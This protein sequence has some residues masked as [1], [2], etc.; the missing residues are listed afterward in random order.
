MLY[1]IFV[2]K[3]NMNKILLF[4]A[5]TFTFSF[6]AQ[7]QITQADFATAGDTV[8]L[9]QASDNGY[10]YLSTGAAFVW[11]F[12]T[13]TPNSQIIKEFYATSSAPL[14]IQFLLGTFAPT[15]YNST[16]YLESTALPI[17]QITSF[18]PITI[19]NIYQF[20][21]SSVDSLTSVGY[22]M[23]IS[24]TEIP[25]QSDTIETHYDLPLQYG[26]SHVS[27]GYTL[28]DFNPVADAKWNQHRERT[29]TVDG[30]GSITTPYGTFNAIRVKHDITEVD[31]IYYTFPFV[32]AIWI[33]LP[34]PTSHEYEWWTNG[35]KEPILKITTNEVLGNELVTAIE[36]RDM[37]RF[38]DAG[39]TDL[40][41]E[42]KVFPNPATNEVNI[43]VKQGMTGFKVFDSKGIVIESKVLDMVKETQIDVAHYAVGVYQIQ[44]ISGTK[45]SVKTFVKR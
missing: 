7:I 26:N 38:L 32:G 35:E 45:S 36:Y 31:S 21:K 29:T 16:Y 40:T 18:L 15:R 19:E 43:S 33:P 9:S 8:R 39:I 42:F 30:Y 24:G 6:N 41:T 4:A 20:T 22:S 3:T 25:F 12:S 44:L 2:K 27:R 17:A 34:I 28:I 13:L 14:F 10:D 23:N 1:P 5:V 11:D 37:N